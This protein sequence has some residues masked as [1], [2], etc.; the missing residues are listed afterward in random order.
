MSKRPFLI[1]GDPAKDVIDRW[2]KRGVLCK[3]NAKGDE[4][5]VRNF[6]WPF[7]GKQPPKVPT[8]ALDELGEHYDAILAHLV[9][10][11]QTRAAI[12]R[13]WKKQRDRKTDRKQNRPPEAA[14]ATIEPKMIQVSHNADHAIE[15]NSGALKSI[16]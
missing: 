2:A 16:S 12:E 11:K 8:E 10:W 15:S 1:E 4:I 3:L 6:S 9:Y 5:V 7:E 13:I 14:R